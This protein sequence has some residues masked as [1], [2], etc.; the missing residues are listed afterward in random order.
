[1]L[2][3]AFLGEPLQG[4]GELDHI[5]HGSMMLKALIIDSISEWKDT[6]VGNN[7]HLRL[8]RMTAVSD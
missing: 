4:F 5:V 7:L 3:A 8:I 6:Q 1:M 2:V